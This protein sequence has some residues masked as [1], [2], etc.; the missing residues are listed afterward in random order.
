MNL[1]NYAGVSAPPL[2]PTHLDELAA[3]GIS[4]E[5]AA[6]A[7]VYTAVNPYQVSKLLNWT[8]PANALGLCLVFPYFNPQGNPTG[9]HRLKPHCPRT[10]RKKEDQ[11][12]K[13]KYEGP[14]GQPNRLYIPPGTRA[15]IADPTAELVITEGEKKSLSATAAGF[16]C[17]SIPGVWA[18]Q[19]KRTKGGDGTATGPRVM[20]D[21]LKEVAW[22]GRRVF[23]AFD[24]DAADNPLVLAAER[25]LVA[26]LTASEAEVRVVRLPAG[27]SGGKQGLDDFLV[28]HGPDALGRLLAAAAAQPPPD[29][30]A[31]SGGSDGDR[32]AKRSNAADLI[33]RIA[34]D[35]AELWHDPTQAAFASVGRR[36][37]GVRS[38]AFRNWLIALYRVESGGKVPNGESLTNAINAT[39]AQ[40]VIDGPEF[41]VHVR[42]AHL[43]GRV[44]L[45]LADPADTVVEVDA[46]GWRECPDPPVRFRRAPGMF[47][48]PRPEPGGSLDDLRTLLNLEDLD[49]FALIV[50]FLSGAMFPG[51]PQPALVAN[52]EQGSGKT[53]VSRVLKALIDPSAAPVRCEPRDARDLMIAARNTHLLVL[54][55]LSHLPAWLSDALCRLATGGGFATRELYSDDGE[56]I[57]DARRPVVLNGIEDFVTRGDLLERSILLRLPSIPEERR[58]PESEFWKRFYALRPKL[59]GALLDRT[60][61]GLREL[62][63]VHLDRLPRMADFA[64]W[65]VACEQGADE[66]ERFL[67]AYTANQGGAHE[68]ALDGSS[69][70]AAVVAFMTGR[71]RWEGTATELYQALSRHTPNPTPRD[72]PKAAN[73]LS[74]KLSRLAPNLRRVHRLDFATDRRT[75]SGRGRVARLTHTPEDGGERPSGPSRPSQGHR[76]QRPWPDDPSDDV[77]RHR[78]EPSVA[79]GASGRGSDGPDGPDDSA[80]TTRLVSAAEYAAFLNLH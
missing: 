38:K 80:P 62:P 66:P 12:K 19:V 68:Q 5:V 51:Q 23:V 18:W 17:L 34:A 30:P 9:Y 53:T 27:P 67:P 74:G 31:G 4:P 16:P 58:V 2:H 44:Y 50:G 1:P 49:Q 52:G 56:V 64:R 72:W 21:D 3:S 26:A 43:E 79:L 14:K 63:E 55:N 13:S 47:A 10:S 37:M 59:L 41:E 70:A 78:R 76:D 45:H 24:S 36:T 7:G 15:A 77:H 46:D 69:L 29:P 42:I 54:D 57:F 61:G 20:I 65:G 25:E 32:E 73:S 6:A 39:E 22:A 75:D 33:A 60:A 35:K 8:R 28:R 11:G 48:L 40:A 71:E